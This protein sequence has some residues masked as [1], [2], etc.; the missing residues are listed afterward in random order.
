MTVSSGEG[1]FGPYQGAAVI[2]RIVNDSMF[3][4]QLRQAGIKNA[5]QDKFILQPRPADAPEYNIK[6]DPH[7]SQPFYW[8]REGLERQGLDLSADLIGQ[9]SLGDGTRPESKK[10]RLPT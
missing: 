4:I 10:T 7:H 2:V 8:S 6:L 5:G 9:V 3:P 1:Q